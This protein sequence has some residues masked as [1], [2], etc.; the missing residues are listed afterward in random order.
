MRKLLILLLLFVCALASCQNQEEEKGDGDILRLPLT[1]VEGIGP[2]GGYS[3]LSE[4]HKKDDPSAEMWVKTYLPVNGIPESWREK[5]YGIP[6]FIPNGLPQPQS[7]ENH[8][9]RV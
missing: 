7:R 2:G 1:F 9:G 6:G 4:E 8:L 5:I 3:L